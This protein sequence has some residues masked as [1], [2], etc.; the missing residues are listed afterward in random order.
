MFISQG[1]V[2][3]Q[4]WRGELF[5]NHVIEETSLY[6]VSQKKAWSFF[7]LWYSLGRNVIKICQLLVETY[8]RKF[9]TNTNAQE[10]TSHFICSY[11]T[12]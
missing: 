10:T 3:T 12:L 2:A 5:N 4:F 1:S 8:T 7:H 9:E 6:S 11:S